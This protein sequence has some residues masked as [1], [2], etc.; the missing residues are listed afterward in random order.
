MNRIESLID[1]IHSRVWQVDTF[2]VVR[3]PCERGTALFSRLFFLLLSSSSLD[4]H[5]CVKKRDDLSRFSFLS[6]SYSTVSITSCSN[7]LSD[8]GCSASRAVSLLS[9][10]VFNV[11]WFGLCHRLLKERGCSRIYPQK[12]GTKYCNLFRT[13]LYSSRHA[14]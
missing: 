10:G 12:Q 13:L 7:S 11:H 2:S 14:V 4:A 8:G 5:A 6:V 1:S 9:I 3:C